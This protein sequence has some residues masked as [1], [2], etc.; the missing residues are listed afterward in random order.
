MEAILT[1]IPEVCAFWHG[2]TDIDTPVLRTHSAV[3]H[4]FPL[5]NAKINLP[6]LIRMQFAPRLLYF[7]R[8]QIHLVIRNSL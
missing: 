5:N 1:Q 3:I 2:N 7:Q 6:G 8:N 4:R